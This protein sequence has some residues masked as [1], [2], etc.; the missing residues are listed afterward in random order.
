MSDVY[1]VTGATALDSTQDT[2]LVP[3]GVTTRRGY[4]GTMVLS[5]GGT[6]A[7]NN[8]DWVVQRSTVSGTGSAVTPMVI[9]DGA[10]AA[11]ILWEQD[12][13]TEPTYTSATEVF[14][15]AINQRAVFTFQARPGFEWVIPAAADDGFGFGAS[16]G[17]ITLTNKVTVHWSE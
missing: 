4:I 12:Q 10:P 1:G 5:V 11:L 16:H 17:S 15:H 9:T 13:S 8:I 2:T 7:D 6:P 14:D 3:I